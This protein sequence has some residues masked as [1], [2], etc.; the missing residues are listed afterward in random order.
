MNR[1]HTSSPAPRSHRLSNHAA[2]LL[3]LRMRV[4]LRMSRCLSYGAGPAPSTR[5][6]L[7]DGTAN[8]HRTRTCNDRRRPNECSL[9]A[10]GSRPSPSSLR[11]RR[12]L[13]RLLRR[14]KCRRGR[15]AGRHRWAPPMGATDERT[16]DRAEDRLAGGPPLGRLR[17]GRAPVRVG[18]CGAR[19]LGR[20]ACSQHRRKSQRHN[21]RDS[22][23][24]HGATSASRRRI[25]RALVAA[26]GDAPA[27]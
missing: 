15:P 4:R 10:R 13:L 11:R 9:C 17:P 16:G 7:P 3:W 22:C 2:Q 25:G 21:L 1:L 20:R 6:I 18:P 14:W 5:P 19:R 26:S 27:R 8:G 12:P 23:G 24:V